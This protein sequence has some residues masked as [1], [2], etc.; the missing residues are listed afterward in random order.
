MRISKKR[1]ILKTSQKKRSQ[2]ILKEMRTRKKRTTIATTLRKMR[3]KRRR[4]LPNP[5]NTSKLSPKKGRLTKFL[6]ML[7]SPSKLTAKLRK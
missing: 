7:S 5:P 1:T 4:Y 6:K 2:K 3:T